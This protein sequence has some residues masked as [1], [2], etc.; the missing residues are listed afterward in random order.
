MHAPVSLFLLIDKHNGHIYFFDSLADIQLKCGNNSQKFSLPIK[1]LVENY[2]HSL[3]SMRTNKVLF[4]ML[5]LK[6]RI[7]FHPFFRLLSHYTEGDGR[8]FKD[9]LYQKYLHWYDSQQSITCGSL[10][11]PKPASLKVCASSKNISHK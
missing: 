1:L 5:K 11:P 2:K 6:I 9:D 8:V 3:P 7:H 10:P 4:F